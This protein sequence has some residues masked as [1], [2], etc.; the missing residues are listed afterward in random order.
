MS[1]LDWDQ[2]EHISDPDAKKPED[3]D[4]SIDGDWEAPT[5]DN[6]KYKGPWRARQI[7]NPN[8]KGPWI[9]PEI[10][11]P[12]YFEDANL[13]LFKD[14]GAVGID[15]WQVKSGSIFDNI[16]ITD[17]AQRAK[18]FARETWD[19]TSVGEKKMKDEQDAAEQKAAETERK[20]HE[21]GE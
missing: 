4:D 7:D 10:D 19:K 13:Y 8:Y 12:D 21:A 2:P 15:I 11:N 9:H 16:L 17:S 3:W 20:I 5:I 6:P 1:G 14:I 18:E